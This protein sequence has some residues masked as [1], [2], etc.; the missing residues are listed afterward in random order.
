MKL[1]II[2]DDIDIDG[3]SC[4]RNELEIVGYVWPSEYQVARYD[5]ETRKHI[6]SCGKKQTSGIYPW[7]EADF[8]L[9]EKEIIE[10]KINVLRNPPPSE[11]EMAV[12]Y[13]SDRF[14]EYPE[15]GDQLDAIWKQFNQYRLSGDPLISE[16]DDLLNQILAVKNKFPKPE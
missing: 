5:T 6:R 2:E 12:K 16:A 7:L 11:Q 4:T 14:N 13:K 1:S 3:F 15:I 10:Q 8:I 9:S